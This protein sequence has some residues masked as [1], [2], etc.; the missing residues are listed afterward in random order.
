M[1]LLINAVEA[2]KEQGRIT[3]S[4]RF[5]PKDQT[6]EADIVDNGCGISSENLP[7]IFEPFFSTKEKGTGLGLSVSF[8]IIQN[9]QGRFDVSSQSG[10]GTRFSIILP[11]HPGEAAPSSEG[12]Q[13]ASN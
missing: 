4:T 10:S 2:T 6:M 13:V 9:H 1:N 12:H 3:V 11:V 5:N 8:G 7:R